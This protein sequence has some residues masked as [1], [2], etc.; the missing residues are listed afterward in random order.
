MRDEARRPPA[1][2]AGTLVWFLVCTPLTAQTAVPS[3][4]DSARADALRRMPVDTCVPISVGSVL[5]FPDAARDSMPP[6]GAI[7]GPA[8][9]LC[10]PGR[11][12]VDSVGAV[13]VLNNLPPSAPNTVPALVTIYDPSMMGDTPPIR[14][15]GGE[16]TGMSW[17]AGLAV[18]LG[19]TVY[20]TNFFRNAVLV[21]PPQ[22]NGNVEPM[23]VITGE[24]TGLDGPADILSAQGEL[25]VANAGTPSITVYGPDATGN[26]APAR[27]I[28]GPHTLLRDPRRMALGRGDTLYVANE[29]GSRF[30]IDS[31]VVTVYA[32]GGTDDAPPC[33]TLKLMYRP[34]GLALDATGH[35]YVGDRDGQQISVYAPGAQGS[36]QPIRVVKGRPTRI[37]GATDLE[38]DSRGWLIVANL[39][40]RERL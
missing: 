3:G 24:R 14:R 15:I 31:A 16:R 23:R 5:V 17:T 21:Y 30:R 13:Y 2:M 10:G 18:D 36:A 26:N 11:L 25:Y 8:T 9:R 39:P 4:A 19:G 1:L 34:V 40:A 12:A 7:E 29:Y 32:P 38:I 27:I 20:V 33:R 28:R 22:A 6:L 35:L 37:N